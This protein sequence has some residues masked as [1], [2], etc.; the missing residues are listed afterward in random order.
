[1]IR[2][3]FA[4]VT[5]WTAP[6][7]VAA[8][9]AADD[10]SL[11]CGVARSAARRRLSDVTASQSEGSI[12]GSVSEALQSAEVDV[13]VDYTS[14][15]AV[16][17]NVLT[18]VR[19]GVHVVVGSSGLTSDD[20]AELDRLARDRGVGVV[21][22][23]NFSIMAAVMKRAAALAAQYLQHWEILDYASAEKPDVPSGTSREL[24]ESLAEVRTPESAVP[25]PQLEG[26]VEARGAEVAGTRIHSVRL[27]SFVVTTEIVFA[28]A[29]ER[30][31]MRHD[32]GESADP[33]VDGTLLAIRKAGDVPGVRR[34][35]D[36]LLR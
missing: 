5:G 35:L 34:G 18:A 3:C 4:G 32:P 24:A 31:V 8:I 21:A 9:D 15:A 23:G 7:I 11:S 2:V 26:P 12:Y 19:A 30:L 1:V 29:G 6:S 14:A 28:G 36:S 10:L 33:Y 13:L 20:Y 16:K 27:P 17:D 22:A 25:L